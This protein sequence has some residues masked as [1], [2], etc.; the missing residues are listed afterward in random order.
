MDSQETAFEEYREQVLDHVQ[1]MYSDKEDTELDVEA[2]IAAV[3]EELVSPCAEEMA[4]LEKF[5]SYF[6]EDGYDIVVS[7]RNWQRC[8]PMWMTSN[9]RPS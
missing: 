3:E 9:S 2:A 7:A 8:N 4:A 6:Q 1:E 5:V